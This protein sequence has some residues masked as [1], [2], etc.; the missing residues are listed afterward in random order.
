MAWGEASVRGQ[1]LIMDHSTGKA[2]LTNGFAATMCQYLQYPCRESPRPRPGQWHPFIRPKFSRKVKQPY[3]F[4]GPASKRKNSAPG[5]FDTPLSG[6]RPPAVLFP[7]SKIKPTMAFND[8]DPLRGNRREM[9]KLFP[10]GPGGAAPCDCCRYARIIV[11]R[12]PLIA[13]ARPNAATGK[14]FF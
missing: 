6:A 4:P 5:P 9:G 7:I 3:P 1:S 13:P 10:S 12:L 8:V 11:S 2:G 14:F